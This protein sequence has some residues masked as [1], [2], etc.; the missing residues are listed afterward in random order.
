MRRENKQPNMSSVHELGGVG[1][2]LCINSIKVQVRIS[3]APR[4]E[5]AP[6]KNTRTISI[7]FLK[8]IIVW[9]SKQKRLSMS[10]T[11]KAPKGSLT[12]PTSGWNESPM[13]HC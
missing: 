6:T 11:S 13:S 10:D 1:I 8:N 7:Y 5:E 4:G 2:T 9:V 3:K 12:P